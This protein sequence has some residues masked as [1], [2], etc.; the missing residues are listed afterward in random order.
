MYL[1]LHSLEADDADDE[2][3]TL[4]AWSSVKSGTR[5]INVHSRAT[6]TKNAT[7]HTTRTT[8]IVLLF[9]TFSFIFIRFVSAASSSSSFCYTNSTK[10]MHFALDRSRYDPLL[11]RGG[12]TAS[13]RV[14]S[15]QA[16][17]HVLHG[18][19]SARKWTV[20]AAA[21]L[22]QP[23]EAADFG[24]SGRVGYRG[25]RVVADADAAVCDSSYTLGR[26][27]TATELIVERLIAQRTHFVMILII[28]LMCLFYTMRLLFSNS[29]GIDV[30]FLINCTR[31]LF[32]CFLNYHLRLLFM[33][34]LLKS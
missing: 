15:L 1:F 22:A 31:N 24:R 32:V 29:V 28:R 11:T 23:R 8:R 4:I 3:N 25:D 18:A 10:R 26:R 7:T 34:K 6:T 9:G 20:A 16:H 17:A 2:L 14:C 13:D 12:K 33:L 27:F 5:W 21:T 19:K 30:F